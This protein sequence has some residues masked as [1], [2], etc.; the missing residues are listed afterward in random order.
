LTET[1][2]VVGVQIVA[3]NTK[4]VERGAADQLFINAA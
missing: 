4:V 3:G 2:R 1:A